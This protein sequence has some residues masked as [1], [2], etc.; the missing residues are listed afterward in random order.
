MQKLKIWFHS[1]KP[2]ERLIFGGGGGIVALV[3]IYTLGLAPFYHSINTTAERV[4][5]KQ[6]DLAWMR[7]VTGEMQMLAASQ[8]NVVAASNESLVVVIDRAA[9][10]CGLSESLT[11]QTPNGDSGIRVR[12]ESAAFDVLVTCM[13]NLERAHGVRIETAQFDRTAKPGL[14]NASLVFNR[15]A[16]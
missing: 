15:A 16:G 12:L 3:A 6:G 1:L 9:R 5:R 11:G 2:R 7:S 4:S 13:G 14:V 8:P 10:E